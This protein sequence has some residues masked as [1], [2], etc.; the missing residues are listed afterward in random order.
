MFAKHLPE[1]N[2]FVLNDLVYKCHWGITF[3]DFKCEWLFSCCLINFIQLYHFLV[4]EISSP[5]ILPTYFKNYIDEICVL[6]VRTLS[7]IT[8]NLWLLN[9]IFDNSMLQL[10]QTIFN[11]L[12][13]SYII[14]SKWK[15]YIHFAC[16]IC[17]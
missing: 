10:H 3:F 13:I 7:H 17:R 4:C 16:Y 1:S 15:F 14:I 2:H 5:P 12:L 11:F 8:L 9:Y 6:S